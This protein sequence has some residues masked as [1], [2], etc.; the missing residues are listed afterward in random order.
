MTASAPNRENALKFIEYLASSE[1]QSIYASAVN[2]YP[3]DPGAQI[4]DR[5]ASWGSF[6]A[7]VTDLAAIAARRAEAL[8]MVER[9]DFDGAPDSD[10]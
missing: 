2:E 3:A 9:V 4:S 1:A 7:D 6:D 5:V 10:S 8:K